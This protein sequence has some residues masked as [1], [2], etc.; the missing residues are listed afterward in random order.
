MHS[1]SRSPHSL[2]LALR[3]AC[4]AAGIT[5]KELGARTDLR[6]ATISSLESGEGATLDTFFAV[7]THVKLELHMGE[8]SHPLTALEGIF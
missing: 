4:L 8:R 2:G 6:Q 1:V 5:Q 3:Q 7:I